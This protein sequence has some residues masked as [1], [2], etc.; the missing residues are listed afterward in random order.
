MLEGQISTTPLTPVIPPAKRWP[1]LLDLQDNMLR[2]IG[3]A[4]LVDFQRLAQLPVT[5]E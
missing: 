4:E 2:P 5:G 1:L 3:K